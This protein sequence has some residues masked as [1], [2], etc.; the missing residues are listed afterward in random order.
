[1]IMAQNSESTNFSPSDLEVKDINQQAM[2]L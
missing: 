1:M 2:R